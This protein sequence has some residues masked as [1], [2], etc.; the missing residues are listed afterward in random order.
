MFRNRRLWR[1]APWL[2]LVVACDPG[3]GPGIGPC[4]A[5]SAET[6][7][8]AVGAYTSVDGYETYGCIMFPA[9]ASA[10]EVEYLVVPQAATGSPGL[11]LNFVLQSVAA[12]VAAAAR[13]TAA[14]EA[15]PGGPAQRFHEFLRRGEEARAWGALRPEHGPAA[16]PALAG[17]RLAKPTVGE[18]RTFSVCSSL[19][20]SSFATVQAEARAV[21]QRLAIFIDQMAPPNGLSAADLDTLITLFDARLYAVDTAAFGRESDINQDEVVIVLMTNVVNRLVSDAECRESGYVSGFFLGA[22]I[23]PAYRNDSR[24]NRAEVFYSIVAD[25]N[26]TLSCAHSVSQVKR[27]V[28][29]TFVHEFQHMISYNQHVLIRGARSGE[30]LWLNEGLSHYAEELGGRSFLAEGDNA[31]FTDYLRGNLHNSYN[32]LEDP[33]A[34]FLLASQG[35]GTLE[36]RG[37]QWLYVRYLVDQYAADNTLAAWNA[38]TRRLV[39]TADTGAT[40]VQRVTGTPFATTV[41]RWVLANW[42]D[43]LPSFATPAELTYESWNFRSVYAQ[44][45]AQDPSRYPRAFPLVPTVT[46]ASAVD[47]SGTLKAGSGVYHRALHAAGAPAF[48]LEFRA[49]DGWVL[50]NTHAPRLNVIRIR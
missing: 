49:P 22:D 10:A 41:T 8:L 32:F 50:A 26:G 31:T 28:P 18:E 27:F 30:Q 37:A 3:T 36:E 9:N 4:T 24:F 44:L 17:A 40:N 12:S 42:V 46:Q 14:P 2:I 5:A 19:D 16:A 25:P 33:G 15:A 21:G 45:N 38:F 13:V 39:Q 35:I 20:C 47:L 23:D 6:V 48:V 34:H 1:A 29:I 7:S 11:T 43:D